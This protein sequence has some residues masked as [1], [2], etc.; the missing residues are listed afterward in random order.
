[1]TEHPKKNE[2]LAIRLSDILTRLNSGQKLTIKQLAQEYQTHP[3]TILRDFN[4]RFSYLP[5]QQ[6]GEFYFLDTRYLGQLSFSDIQNFAK[7]SGIRNLYPSLDISFMREL[8]D[9]RAKS[10]YDAKGY[11]FENAS[12]FKKH[13]EVL[14]A[15]MKEKKQ[16]GFLY[17]NE[18]RVVEPY[19]L[20]H[21]HGCWYLAAVRKGELRAYRLSRITLS[22]VGHELSHFEPDIEILKQLE[23]EESI[24]FGQEK[25]EVILTVHADVAQHFKQ[26]QLL[27][28]QNVIKELDDGSLLVSSKITHNTQLLPLVRFWIPH[29][30]IV[31]P[32]GMQGELENQ[33]KEYLVH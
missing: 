15:A 24:W 19:R 17:N 16:I 28:E 4:E 26:R 11:F 25:N 5:I 8:L 2:K 3:R 10:I 23:N 6:E 27:P 12:Q 20:V 22:N 33:L 7:L 30:K 29:V 14:S 21:H 1:M 18:S 9:S 32:E 13:F 31:N